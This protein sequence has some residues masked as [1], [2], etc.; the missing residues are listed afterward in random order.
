MSTRDDYIQ[1][2]GVDAVR[3]ANGED[4]HERME[5]LRD[6]FAGMALQGLLTTERQGVGDLDW[7][8]RAYQIAD[9]MLKARQL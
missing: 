6:W 9:E 7:V 5:A 3:R 8:N 1:K 4:Y 2:Y